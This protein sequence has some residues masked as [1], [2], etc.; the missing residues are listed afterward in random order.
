MFFGGEGHFE[1]EGSPVDEEI[2]GLT[3]V[4][5]RGIS[6]IA[7]GDV[8]AHVSFIDCEWAVSRRRGIATNI[9]SILNIN[10]VDDWL[11]K[12]IR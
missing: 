4:G 7:S 6:V 5:G 2:K 11:A 8:M 1:I 3:F 9:D 10:Y 12:D